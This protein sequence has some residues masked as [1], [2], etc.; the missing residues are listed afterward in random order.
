MTRPQ[1]FISGDLRGRSERR[2]PQSS[3]SAGLELR[4]R[5][6]QPSLP[7]DAVGRDRSFISACWAYRGSFRAS[8]ARAV[9]VKCNWLTFD[10]ASSARTR[11]DFTSLKA[12]QRQSRSSSQAAY[13]LVAVQPIPANT[14]PTHQATSNR[15]SPLRATTRPFFTTTQRGARLTIASAIVSPSTRTKSARSP[16]ETP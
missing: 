11:A 6:V 9:P 2:R 4:R 16:C 13:P 3:G 10:Q 8:S 7:A 5:H 1:I 14:Q 12:P 15:A